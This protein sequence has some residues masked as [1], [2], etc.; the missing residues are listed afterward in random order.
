MRAIQ[1]LFSNLDH[2]RSRFYLVFFIGFIDGVVTFFIPVALSY[3]VSSAIAPGLA[4]RL[5]LLIALLSFASHG[6]QFILRS[7]GESLGPQ[8]SQYLRIKY[9]QRLSV[10]PLKDLSKHH[11][12][13]LL[14][15]VSVVADGMGGLTIEL[16]W[17]LSRA[18]ANIGLFF[19]FSWKQSLA[20]A[21]FNSVILVAFVLLS[22]LLSRRLVP[23]VQNLSLERAKLFAPFADLYNTLFG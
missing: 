16:F 19:F 18:F 15:L 23:A 13:Y 2:F 9:F 1:L 21:M 4:L 17:G 12:G 3:F 14:T 10:L 7:V 22:G 5:T 6:M 8:L 11:S 20:M